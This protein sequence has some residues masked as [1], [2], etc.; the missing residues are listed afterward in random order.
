MI[1]SICNCIRRN[2]IIKKMFITTQEEKNQM[3][4]VKCQCVE[5]KSTTLELFWPRHSVLHRLSCHHR[6]CLD[7]MFDQDLPPRF[8]ELKYIADL[9]PIGW[10]CFRA[11]SNCYL[12]FGVPYYCSRLVHVLTHSQ[13][14]DRSSSHQLILHRGQYYQ[15]IQNPVNH[16]IPWRRW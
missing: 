10:W 13:L 9:W 1:P 7:R 5:D 15:R 4:E 16:N 6:H 8:D 11:M 12:S 3:T 14:V 2:S